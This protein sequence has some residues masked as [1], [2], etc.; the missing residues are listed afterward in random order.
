MKSVVFNLKSSI[1]LGN[2]TKVKCVQLQPQVVAIGITNYD[3]T[4][5]KNSYSYPIS[6]DYSKGEVQIHVG[7]P[8]SSLESHRVRV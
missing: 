4:R 2:N 8:S 7:N 5:T 6:I 3:A 1:G